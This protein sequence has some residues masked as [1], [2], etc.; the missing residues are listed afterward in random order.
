MNLEKK[1]SCSKSCALKKDGSRYETKNISGPNRESKLMLYFVNRS[2]H[3]LRLWAPL[4][5][6]VSKFLKMFS[7]IVKQD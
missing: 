2:A 4:W 7:N 6:N 1:D 5:I 3:S